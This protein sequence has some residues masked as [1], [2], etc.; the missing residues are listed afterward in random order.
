MVDNREFI[1]RNP[2][3]AKS[4]LLK[5]WQKLGENNEETPPQKPNVVTVPV[6]KA[7]PPPPL[8]AECKR[9]GKFSHPAIRWPLYALGGY[10]II[11]WVWKKWKPKDHEEGK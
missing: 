3:S 8:T 10:L 4:S 6:P 7:V 2:K 1:N 9:P 11:S 5:N